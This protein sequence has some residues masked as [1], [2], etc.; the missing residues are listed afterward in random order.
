[1][2]LPTFGRSAID[3]FIQ[4][5]D[6]MELRTYCWYPPRFQLG[7]NVLHYL[8]LSTTDVEGSVINLTPAA[9]GIAAAADGP[10]IAALPETAAFLGCELQRISPTTSVTGEGGGSEAWGLVV[11]DA[12]PTQVSGLVQLRTNLPGRSGRGRFYPPFPPVSE[13][14]P[15]A[16]P[17]AVFTAVLQNIGDFF[18]ALSSFGDGTKT[19]TIVLGVWSPTNDTFEAIE[20]VV[21]QDAWA[22]Q[23]RRGQYGRPNDMPAW[24]VLPA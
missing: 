11:S 24:A 7:I 12:L 3:A 14:E 23:R 17:S 21:A 6:I 16:F 18:G 8:V 15:G 2:S 20:D 1:M 19:A 9:E 13:N 5:G 22:T 10:Y 4:A